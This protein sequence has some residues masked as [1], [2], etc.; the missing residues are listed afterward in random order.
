MPETGIIDAVDGQN[1]ARISSDG[2]FRQH[3]RGADGIYE[4][5]VTPNQPLASDA[6]IVIKS[7]DLADL[8]ELLVLILNELIEIKEN[9]CQ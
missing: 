9:F 5:V 1:G 6:G 2:A 4:A 3:I 8:K 7:N